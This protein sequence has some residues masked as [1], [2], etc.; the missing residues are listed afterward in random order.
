ME[1]GLKQKLELKTVACAVGFFN[2]LLR[3]L[4]FALF[5]TKIASPRNILIFK[6][7]NIGDIL[8]A[9]PSFVAVRK[10]Y[11]KAK[12][13]LLTSPGEKQTPGAAELLK[14][15]WFI[16]EMKTYNSD[17]ISSLKDAWKLAE[18]LKRGRFDFFVQIPPHEWVNFRTLAR[19]M[20]FAK[21]IGAKY[22]VGFRMRVIINL[23]RKTQ[24]DYVDGEKE[25]ESLL[26]ILAR[27][28]I[29]SDKVEFDLPISEADEK[30]AERLLLDKWNDSE[31]KFVVA[32]HSGTKKNF[33]EKRWK[34]E[35]FGQIARYLI[36]KYGV[37]IVIAGG[38]GDSADADIIKKYLPAE[39]V[40]IAAGELSILES[41]ALLKRCDFILGI[42]SGLLH[43]AAA[44]SK[45]TVGLYSNLDIFGD[46]F[47]YGNGHIPV[48]HRFLNCDYY[49]SDC[50]RSSMETITV[51]E[52]RAAC[53]KMLERLN[54][55]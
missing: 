8:C 24:I 51:D 20:F 27:E 35:R 15:S 32:I 13:T 40:L 5:H 49:S 38:K 11:P 19:N 34:P 50:V 55:K 26:G 44:V 14:G 41:A 52:V 4:R 21:F 2:V 28:G 18:E 37:K 36:D 33:P 6:V 43:L 54:K 30:R 10:K 7:G 17:N 31:R 9:V 1:I 53:D 39:S 46:W 45:P 47:P 3:L 16:D 22:A 42:D 48:F 25:V 12:I 29:D 23:F